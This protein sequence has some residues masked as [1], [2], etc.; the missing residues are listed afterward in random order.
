MAGVICCQECGGDLPPANSGR[1]RCPKCG[2]EFTYR[3]AWLPLLLTWAIVGAVVSIAAHLFFVAT[4]LHWGVTGWLIVG[5]VTGFLAT[6]V[7]RRF[8]KLRKF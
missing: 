8:R 2:T 7:S 1:V 6:L 4:G 3:I 5:A